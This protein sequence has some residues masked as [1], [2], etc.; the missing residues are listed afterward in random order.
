MIINTGALSRPSI[1]PNGSAGSASEVTRHDVGAIAGGV[2]G[3]LIGLV[4]VGAI[5]WLC[6]SRMRRK[7]AKDMD[8]Q[9]GEL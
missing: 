4:I 9:A 2:A 7:Y 3:S 6:L 1:H 5:V 8:L